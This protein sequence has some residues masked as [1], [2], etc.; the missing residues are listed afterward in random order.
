MKKAKKILFFILI[1]GTLLAMSV[2]FSSCTTGH[3]AY[4]VYRPGVGKCQTQKFAWGRTINCSTY[5]VY[6]Y[7]SVYSHKKQYFFRKKH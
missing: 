6:S 2:F 7:T 5:P 3:W 1:N 4:T